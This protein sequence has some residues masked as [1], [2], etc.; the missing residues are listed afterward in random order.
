[1]AFFSI[2]GLAAKAF[3]ASLT[4]ASLMTGIIGGLLGIIAGLLLVLHFEKVHRK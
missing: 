2:A 3:F 1:L 4:G